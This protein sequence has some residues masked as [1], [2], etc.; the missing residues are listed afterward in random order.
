MTAILRLKRSD[1]SGNPAVLAAGELAYSSFTGTGGHRLY[2][3]TGN[4]TA[5]NA[6][7]HQVIGGKY[8]VDIID[9]ATSAATA[10]KLVLRDANGD[11]AF[12]AVIADYITKTGTTNVG[13]I[14]SSA[15]VFNTVYGTNFSGNSATTTKWQTARN[16]SLTGDATATLSSVDGSAN[17]STALTL[18]TVNSD[19]KTFATASITGNGTTATITFAAQASSPFNVGD[20]ITVSGVTPAGYNGTHTVTACTVSTV[21]YASAIT[22]SM[23]VAGTV[24][25]AFGSGSKIPVLTVNAK[26]LVTAVSTA[27]VATNLNISANT[28][29]DTIDL[30]TDTLKFEGGTGITTTVDAVN[31][32]VVFA[33]GQGVATTDNV[34]F[35]NLT[36]NGNLTVSGTTTTV[37]STVTTISDP[38][39]V[40]GQSGADAS[41]TASA[42]IAA[43]SNATTTTITVADTAITGTISVG[44]RVTDQNS[45]LPVGSYVSAITGTTTKTITVIWSGATTFTAASSIALKFTGPLTDDNKDRGIEFRWFSG[46]GA[47]TGYFG[48]DDS[49][50]Y[51]V[52]IPDARIVGEVATGTLGDFQ[53]TNFRGALIGNAD[54]ATIW[55]TAR[56]LSLTGDATATFSS[57]NG[58]AN[59]STALTL[60]TVNSNVGSFGTSTSV[61]AITVNAKGLVTAVSTNAIPTSTANTTGPLS[62]LG[63]ASFNS[64]EFTVT[65]GWVE[66]KEV[67][68]G[69]Y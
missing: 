27:N 65:S 58:G 49:S 67:N 18:A 9:A 2:I 40:L 31:N 59:V 32:K 57:V 66:L 24:T 11:S 28:G 64:A 51:F 41:T 43:S 68:G 4:E 6:A 25:G 37:N 63:L 38:I 69:T 54:T 60:A 8:Y 53:A 35:N 56:D 21:S 17:V 26:G 61:P 19:I 48:H 16:L 39:L 52:Y 5:G 12:R 10:D 36:L 13:D 15:N 29:S 7:T 62:T 44:M 3:G 14:G 23:T 34:T 33:V 30:L 46:L 42:S 20:K 22:G 1:T 50:G 45:I 55:Q 47:K